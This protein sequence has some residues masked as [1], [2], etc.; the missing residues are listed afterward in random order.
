MGSLPEYGVWKAMMGRCYNPNNNMFKHYGSRGIAVCDRWR[1]RTGFANFM[2][3]MGNRPSPKHSI[4]RI[5]NNGP[6]SPSNCKWATLD[7]QLANRRNSVFM[8]LD[9]ET[10]TASQWAAILGISPHVLYNRRRQGWPDSRAL[11]QPTI[12]R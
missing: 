9:G 7:E 12:R 1:G 4:E 8:T 6:Y 11:T 2:A 10:R 3:D 5:D